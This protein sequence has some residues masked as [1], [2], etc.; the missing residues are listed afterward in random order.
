M[1]GPDKLLTTAD[2]VLKGVRGYQRLAD[3]LADKDKIWTKNGDA[4][5]N[6][7]MDSFVRDTNHKPYIESMEKYISR[8]KAA[9][10]AF[11]PKIAAFKDHLDKLD[12]QDTLL[13]AFQSTLKELD[14]YTS[15]RPDGLFDKMKKLGGQARD[16]KVKQALAKVADPKQAMA[17]VEEWDTAWRKVL[18]KLSQSEKPQQ[19]QQLGGAYGS[20]RGRGRHGQGQGRGNNNNN[21]QNK[22][23]IYKNFIE[24]ASDNLREIE[25]ILNKTIDTIREKLERVPSSVKNIDKEKASGSKGRFKRVEVSLQSYLDW[26]SDANKPLDVD[27]ERLKVSDGEVRLAGALRLGQLF[28][29]SDDPFMGFSNFLQTTQSDFQEFIKKAKADDK[30]V[31]VDPINTVMALITRFITDVRITPNS[32]ITSDQNVG[33]RMIDHLNKISSQVQIVYE[34]QIAYLQSTGNHRAIAESAIK[35]TDPNKNKW[36]SSSP[37]S[38]YDKYTSSI[39]GLKEQE[40]SEERRKL[41]ALMAKDAPSI[42]SRRAKPKSMH[43]YHDQLQRFVQRLKNTDTLKTMEEMIFPNSDGNI[44]RANDDI[45]RVKKSVVGNVMSGGAREGEEGGEGEG[46]ANDAKQEAAEANEAKARAQAKAQDQAEAEA[47]EKAAKEAEEAKEAKELEEVK[48]K[49]VKNADER[50]KRDEIER[51]SLK[52]KSPEEAEYEINEIGKKKKGLILGLIDSLEGAFDNYARIHADF[53]LKHH[54]DGLRYMLYWRNINLKDD[55][56]KKIVKEYFGTLTEILKLIDEQTIAIK[57]SYSK[58]L[59]GGDK[60]PSLAKWG[61]GMTADDHEEVTA[62]IQELQDHL[63]EVRRDSMMLYEGDGPGIV[64]VLMAAPFLLMYVIKLLRMVFAWAALHFAEHVF[65]M[66]YARVAYGENRDPPTP[67]MMIVLFLLIDVTM[68]AALLA[69]MFLLR[70]MFS[71]P[72]SSFPIDDSFIWAY[73]VDYVCTTLA[74]FVISVII[75]NI[76]KT[77]KYFRYRYEG[78]RGIRALKVMTLYVTVVIMLIPF[79]RLAPMRV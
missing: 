10:E 53:V 68:N 54:R 28:K 37:S 30:S 66:W 61:M 26:Y 13:N 59:Q 31:P 4:I 69:V 32:D 24:S 20:G 74:I 25:S 41:D 17:V 58:A 2:A 35:S 7:I 78:E 63:E 72:S 46:E 57:A 47:K 73:V 36:S 71:S 22:Q 11:A 29:P 21:N 3:G 67:V 6:I 40:V 23:K 48:A 49:Q 16:P 33:K 34:R 14:S 45:E 55:E 44:K 27:E 52:P 19:Q 8:L 39:S 18:D 62:H 1:S 50:E 75:A 76:V 5:E 9:M 15:Q 51:K 64:N 42:L 60:Y 56:S 65:Q 38:G 43:M 70:L 12:N 79:F 77:K